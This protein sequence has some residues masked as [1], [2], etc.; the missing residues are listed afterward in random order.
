MTIEEMNRAMLVYTAM[1]ELQRALLLG[2]S[3]L[4]E[5]EKELVE[6]VSVWLDG[7]RREDAA[8][9]TPDRKEGESMTQKEKYKRAAS[10]MRNALASIVSDGPSTEYLL[11]AAKDEIRAALPYEDSD[12]WRAD[13]PAEGIAVEAEKLETE[14]EPNEGE[15]EAKKLTR[16]AV[17]EKARACVCGEREEDYGSPEDSFGCIAEL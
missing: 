17:L 14:D 4:R 6:A 2:G 7:R 9:E 10:A 12:Y 13:A 16:A 5:R 3:A 8:Q 15:G 11:R 1:H